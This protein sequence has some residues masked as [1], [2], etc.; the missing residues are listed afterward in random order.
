MNASHLNTKNKKQ[1]GA[2]ALAILGLAMASMVGM[3]RAQQPITPPAGAV[4]WL[5]GERSFDD[6]AGFHNGSGH[7]ATFILG[8]VGQGLRFDGVDDLVA[9]DVTVAEQRAV[10]DTFTYE[11]W[12][13]PTAPLPACAQS[14]NS[15][16]GSAGLRWA[17][18][19]NHGETA[20]PPGEGGAAA[21]IGIAIGTNAVC[22]GEH[23]SF[24][25]DCLARLD[26]LALNDWTHIAVVVQD[27]IPRIYLNGV[28]AHT[29]IASA[30]QFV[31]A[32]W[33]TIGSGLS[34]GVYAGDLDEVTLYRRA[35]SDI[36][37]ADLFLAGADGKRKPECVVERSDDLWEGALVTSNTPLLSST[38][39]G[40]FG[41]QNVS[42]EATSTIFQDGLPDGTVH[43]VEWETGSPVTLA[44]MALFALHDGLD[45]PNRRFRNLRIQARAVGGSFVTI[46]NSPILLPY[47]LDSR[48]LR[49]CPNVR[50]IFAQQFRVEVVQEG[51]LAVSG[52]RVMELDGLGLPTLIFRDGY[53]SVP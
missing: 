27:R 7:G 22:V 9:V 32:S 39:N 51:T 45:L 46:Y 8:Q 20:A 28:L 14:N 33:N 34:L 1:L 40:M 17:I 38:A 12:A 26:G 47:E 4:Y 42:P 30:K 36:E 13:R 44:S 35:L 23:A 25:V 3:A 52:P 37:I 2:R 29:G 48:E 31:F 53:E 16:C 19:P 5:A 50:P 49:R 24:L 43:A 6:R 15:N 18:F 41:A 21:G 11:L 10:R